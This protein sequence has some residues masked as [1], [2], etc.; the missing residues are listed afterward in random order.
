M[1]PAELLAHVPLG[2]VF[3]SPARTLRSIGALGSSET[4]ETHR[5]VIA[6]IP[7]ECFLTSG[8]RRRAQWC[9]SRNGLLLYAEVGDGPTFNTVEAVAASTGVSA[10]AFEVPN[11]G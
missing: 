7:A 8:G 11:G 9:Y 6:G 2:D 10:D 3:V 4:S 5:R 1:T